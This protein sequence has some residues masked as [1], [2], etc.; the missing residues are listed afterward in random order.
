MAAT[1]QHQ[2]SAVRSQF[3]GQLAAWTA[4]NHMW[5]DGVAKLTDLNVQ[6]VRESTDDSAALSRELMGSASP[7]EA[8]SVAA[9]QIQPNI[10]RLTAYGRQVL[11]I[12]NNM[13]NEFGSV[14]QDEISGTT[15]HATSE[16]QGVLERSS[17][18]SAGPFGEWMKAALDAAN[19]GYEQIMGTT[20]QMSRTIEENLAAASLASS[21]QTEQ[22]S[23]QRARRQ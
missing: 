12:A 21:A 16:M 13:R 19:A 10:E 8:L 18:I 20:V 2:I 15:R 1:I 4:L 17:V 22:L 14:V 6:A 7:Q 5:L 11:N 9:E 3:E 23:R